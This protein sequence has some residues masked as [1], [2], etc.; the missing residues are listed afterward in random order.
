MPPIGRFM[1]SVH[2]LC[3][4]M[5]KIDEQTPENHYAHENCMR[6]LFLCLICFIPWDFFSLFSNLYKFCT[7][8]KC[9]I[10]WKRL[11]Q[12][13]EWTDE[14]KKKWVKDM[15]KE[16]TASIQKYN[17]SLSISAGLLMC[18]TIKSSTIAMAQWT[19]LITSIVS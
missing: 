7:N 5:P 2:N 10:E 18:Q 19:Q 16:Y 4:A 11:P 15:I 3:N 13:N 14:K 17:L 1:W 6:Q 9:V 12:I 8:I